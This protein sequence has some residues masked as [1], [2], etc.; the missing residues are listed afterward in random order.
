MGIFPA[1]E[2]ALPYIKPQ[3]PVARIKPQV[4]PAGFIKALQLHSEANCSCSPLSIQNTTPNTSD[5][6]QE[7]STEPVREYPR[8]SL[9]SPGR[10]VHTSFSRVPCREQFEEPPSLPTHTGFM[11]SVVE[12]DCPLRLASVPRWVS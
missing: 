2:L 1:R 10:H 5:S 12:L 3:N 7:V 9:I 11:A 4:C 6:L 8:T